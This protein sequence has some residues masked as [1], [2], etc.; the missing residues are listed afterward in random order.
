M[1]GALDWN[2]DY[3]IKPKDL[4][5]DHD[6]GDYGFINSKFV[7]IDGGHMNAATDMC[8]KLSHKLGSGTADDDAVNRGQLNTR[9]SLSG[10]TLSGEL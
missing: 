4:A 6:V 3:L 1:N 7:Q 2:D 9:R 8:G 5:S 10:R